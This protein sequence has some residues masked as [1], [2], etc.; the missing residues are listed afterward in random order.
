VRPKDRPLVGEPHPKKWHLRLYGAELVGTALLVAVGVSVVIAMFGAGSPLPALL[1]AA[2]LRRLVTG[3]LFGLTGA[4]VAVSPLGKVS[5][6]HINPAVSVAF[7]LEGK[8]APRDAFGYVVAQLAGGCLAVPVLRAWGATGAS[9]LYGATVPNAAAGPVLAAAGEAGITCALV[10]LI[11]VMGAHRRTERLTPWSLPF[12]FSL[13]VWL[14]APLSGT[15]ANPARTLGPNLLAR[16]LG[17]LWIYFAGPL[18][19][20]AAAVGLVRLE[21]MRRHRPAAARVAH[22]HL[23][24]E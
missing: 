6:A 8:L 14:E 16:E 20:A 21:P 2:G 24:R 10:T 5:G 17:V 12:L 22:F 15:S 9:V 13:L 1:P 23:E 19:G 7:A 3:F 11:F 4:L 18:A